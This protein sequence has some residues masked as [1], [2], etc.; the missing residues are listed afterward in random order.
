M[1]QIKNI[2]TTFFSYSRR[3]SLSENL[4]LSL[5]L[6]SFPEY[7][8]SFWFTLLQNKKEADIM[9]TRLVYLQNQKEH[10]LKFNL[11]QR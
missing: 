8:A 6:T 5:T 7:S 4:V 1:V 2:F 10:Q 3:R 9:V 11:D